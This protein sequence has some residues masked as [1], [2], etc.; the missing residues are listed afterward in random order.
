M[1]SVSILGSTGTI[2]VNTLEVIKLHPDR[3]TIFALTANSQVE[4]LYHQCIKYNP[5]YAVMRDTQAAQQLR[6][7][8]QGYDT[9]VL[10]GEEGLI[11][12]A[13]AVEVDMVIS[14]R[15]NYHLTSKNSDAVN[16]HKI[17]DINLALEEKTSIGN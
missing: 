2:G 14:L 16:H 15:H 6:D 5:R 10:E 9:E 8:L 11:D 7:L 4:K 1:Q 13:S 12:V 3:Y 17:H